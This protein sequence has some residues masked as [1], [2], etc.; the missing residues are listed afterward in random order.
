MRLI[1]AVV[2]LLTGA[3]LIEGVRELFHVISLRGLMR[4]PL[5]YVPVIMAS[6]LVL[7]GC[8]RIRQVSRGK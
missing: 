7:L 2:P 1:H 6:M 3:L 4:T 8:I 5:A